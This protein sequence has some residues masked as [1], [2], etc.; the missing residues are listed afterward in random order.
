MRP[1]HDCRFGEKADHAPASPGLVTQQR[2]SMS[3]PSES[4][5]PA[6]EGP[7]GPRAESCPRPRPPPGDSDSAARQYAPSV[8]VA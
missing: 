5:E 6:E 8:P 7:P 4:P 1:H 2:S 3:T